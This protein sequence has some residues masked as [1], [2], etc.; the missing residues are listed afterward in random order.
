M[1]VYLPSWDFNLPEVKDFVLVTTLQGTQKAGS[2]R[3]S[4]EEM[5]ELLNAFPIVYKSEKL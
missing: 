3:S 1:Y 5:N 2:E 4:N